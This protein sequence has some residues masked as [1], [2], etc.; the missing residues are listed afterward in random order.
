M[1][2]SPDVACSQA[3]TQPRRGTPG[4]A[5]V[6]P[7]RSASPSSVSTSATKPTSSRTRLS[8]TASRSFIASL[9][10]PKDHVGRPSDVFTSGDA[11]IQAP[12]PWN[13][14]FSHPCIYIEASEKPDNPNAPANTVFS[15][16]AG[17]AAASSPLWAA[18]ALEE[19]TMD[20]QS[21]P[22][23]M[24]LPQKARSRHDV[25]LPDLFFVPRL[26]ITITVANCPANVLELVLN[27][28][29]VDTSRKPDFGSMDD[30]TVLAV[31]DISVS[32]QVQP[33]LKLL[34]DF[35]MTRP[36]RDGP[37]WQNE[38]WKRRWW[39]GLAASLQE[40]HTPAGRK[41]SSNLSNRVSPW[42]DAADAYF[43]A[44]SDA[45]R[46]GLVLYKS[47]FE[48]GRLVVDI[49]WMAP[50]AADATAFSCPHAHT[51]P[52]DLCTVR[53]ADGS[54]R[55]ARKWLVLALMALR[56]H[57]IRFPSVRTLKTCS[58]LLDYAAGECVACKPK[59][60]EEILQ[61]ER[62]MERIVRGALDM[63]PFPHHLVVPY[64]SPL[65]ALEAPSLLP[66]TSTAT[67]LSSICDAKLEDEVE[68]ALSVYLMPA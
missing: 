35:V 62:D 15:V 48:G 21:L 39:D 28:C 38:C 11:K 25:R 29:D 33:A 13:N 14:P 57:L 67:S 30:A 17:L 18:L 68:S 58:I 31:L 8:T 51:E 43:T 44:C 42:K 16:P 6:A 52:E 20:E 34:R 63:V 56:E 7:R 32:H 55:Q 40:Q 41:L 12:H 19:R 53:L 66:A 46:D 36:W 49:P 65:E 9:K 50:P 1:S 5:G 47:T 37:R 26:G 10:A 60:Y 4:Q 54:E 2:R 3:D 59:A 22:G 23:A 64:S 61:Y 27:C 24:T 45:L